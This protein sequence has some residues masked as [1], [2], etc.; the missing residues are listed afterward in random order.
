MKQRKQLLLEE[1]QARDVDFE[2]I[3]HKKNILKNLKRFTAAYLSEIA[4]ESNLSDYQTRLILNELWD[5][6]FVEQVRVTEEGD[7]RLI[8]RVSEMSAK[9]Q[10]G[11]V[12]F[13]KKRWFAI[14]EKGRLET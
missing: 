14:T 6:G 13:Q 5:S 8:A 7:P 1:E 9:G 2:T 4:W 12:N 10:G 11:M 3:N